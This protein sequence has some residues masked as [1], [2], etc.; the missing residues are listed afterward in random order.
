MSDEDRATPLEAQQ[1]NPEQ[2][3]SELAGETQPHEDAEQ[4]E[5]ALREA[6]RPLVED[7]DDP[8][9]QARREAPI[10]RGGTSLP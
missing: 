9:L 8:D 2:A 4:L 1:R 6:G 3:T 5:A 7:V 10:D